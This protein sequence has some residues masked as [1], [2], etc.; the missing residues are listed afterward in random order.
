MHSETRALVEVLFL[1]RHTPN[2][3]FDSGVTAALPAGSL[4]ADAA[5]A[6]SLTQRRLTHLPP[7]TRPSPTLT[8]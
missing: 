1:W 3:D 7:D 4:T 5:A 2:K 8:A 6:T